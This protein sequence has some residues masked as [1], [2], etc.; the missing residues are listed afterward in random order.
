[1][2]LRHSQSS[3]NFTLFLTC[4]SG[5]L[6]FASS[7]ETLEPLMPKHWRFTRSPSVPLV[8][9]PVQ[10]TVGGRPLLSYSTGLLRRPLCCA[11][12]CCAVLCCFVLLAGTCAMTPSRLLLSTHPKTITI[13][14]ENSTHGQGREPRRLLQVPDLRPIPSHLVQLHQPYAA[15]KEA[16]LLLCTASATHNT[17]LSW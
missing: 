2:A 14:K 9:E 7:I 13:S 1:M 15:P 5:A 17:C 6:L 12:L 8:S 3:F 10:I 16:F 11:V 4:F